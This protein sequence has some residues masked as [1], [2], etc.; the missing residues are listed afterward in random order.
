MSCG[1]LFK[2]ENFFRKTDFVEVYISEFW[3]YKEL[4]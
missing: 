4:G 3:L 2:N 1:L